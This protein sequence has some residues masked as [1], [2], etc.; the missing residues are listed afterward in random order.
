MICTHLSVLQLLWGNVTCFTF[1]INNVAGYIPILYYLYIH[2]YIKFTTNL[3]RK[4]GKLFCWF[5]TLFGHAFSAVAIAMHTIHCLV[6]KNLASFRINHNILHDIKLLEFQNV[7]FLAV[8]L[9]NN[10]V[11]CGNIFALWPVVY[12]SVHFFFAYFADLYF[13]ILYLLIVYFFL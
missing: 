13:T 5:S 2:I 4:W 9:H 8:R 10:V 7:L 12:I 6:L 3:L 1:V 11:F